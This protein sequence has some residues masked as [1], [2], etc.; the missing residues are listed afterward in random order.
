M[1]ARFGPINSGSCS[2]YRLIS[3]RLLQ[4][5]IGRTTQDTIPDLI[6][7][8]LSHEALRQLIKRPTVGVIRQRRQG[9]FIA[10]LTSIGT[11]NIPSVLPAL[12]EI[13]LISNEEPYLPIALFSELGK[14]HIDMEYIRLPDD[15]VQKSISGVVACD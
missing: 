12:E 4:T 2:F 7:S 13:Q 5:R 14:L 9:E 6:S 15:F 1:V 10:T 3:P 11:Q 8:I